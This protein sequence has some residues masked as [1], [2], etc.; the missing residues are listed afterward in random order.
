M[1]KFPFIIIIYFN[2]FYSLIYIIPSY[3][4]LYKYI[5]PAYFR[6]I[7][8]LNVVTCRNVSSFQKKRKINLSVKA[9]SAPW[10]T[11]QSLQILIENAKYIISLYTALS[12]PRNAYALQC[13][14]SSFKSS[15]S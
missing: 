14:I 8:L 10:H 2:S 11:K 9:F 12:M 15:V 5:F 3:C 1:T 4:S 13:A 7:H 6:R